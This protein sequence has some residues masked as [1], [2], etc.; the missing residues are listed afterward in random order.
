MAPRNTEAEDSFF[1]MSR[2]WETGIMGF[3]EGGG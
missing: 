3:L 1:A 2:Y